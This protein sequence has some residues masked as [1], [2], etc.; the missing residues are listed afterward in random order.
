MRCR[1]KKNLNASR[2]SE[3]LPVRGKNKKMAAKTKPLHGT[4]N[5]FLKKKQNAP[6]P[7]EHPPPVREENMS[8]RLGE[9]KGCK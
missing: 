5:G 6:R 7:S 2:P 8:K 4:L 3:R 1:L 9:I